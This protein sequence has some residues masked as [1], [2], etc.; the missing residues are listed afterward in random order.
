[1]IWINT[2]LSSRDDLKRLNKNE[3][4]TTGRVLLTLGAMKSTLSAYS[5]KHNLSSRGRDSEKT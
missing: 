2:E 3:I 4:N 5:D 1:M